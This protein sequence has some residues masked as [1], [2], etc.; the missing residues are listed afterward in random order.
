MGES[1]DSYIEQQGHNAC[2]ECSRQCLECKEKIK[3]ME[4]KMLKMTIALTSALTLIGQQGMEYIINAVQNAE[5]IVS[6]EEKTPSNKN[7]V[8]QD[9]KFGGKE[10]SHPINFSSYFTKQ[11][12]NKKHDDYEE[13]TF[14]VDTKAYKK[15]N[16]DYSS[17]NSQWLFSNP[18]NIVLGSSTFPYS[19]SSAYKK[20]Y[21]IDFAPSIMA[22]KSLVSDSIFAKEDVS[23]QYDF[24]TSMQSGISIPSPSAMILLAFGGMTGNRSRH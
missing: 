16:I 4:S 21:H 15:N 14:L 17:S 7:S 8:S 12:Y 9:Y 2:P 19:D 20:E 10:G 5:K 6:V 11:E 13:E 24:T 22:S 23:Y 1:P 3:N 18:K